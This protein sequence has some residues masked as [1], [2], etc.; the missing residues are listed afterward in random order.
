MS[1]DLKL[2]DKLLPDQRLNNIYFGGGDYHRA[3]YD[4]IAHT[5][6]LQEPQE[7]FKLALSDKV[8]IEEMASNP[9]QLRFL[10]LIVRLLQPRRIV[11]IGAFIGLSAMTMARAMPEGGRLTTIE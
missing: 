6:G 2:W 11:E 4:L 9:V 8:T 7:T 1:T 10:D 3:L 5:S